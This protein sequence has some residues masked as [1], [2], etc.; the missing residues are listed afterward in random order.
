MT[1]LMLGLRN[2]FKITHLILVGFIVVVFFILDF[3]S[4]IESMFLRLGMGRVVLIELS[5]LI[6]LPFVSL[7]DHLILII[8]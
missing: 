4:I 1:D 6:I 5:L 2:F 8:N 3:R 7:I